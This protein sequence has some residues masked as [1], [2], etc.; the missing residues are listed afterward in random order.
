[1]DRSLYIAMSGAKQILQAQTA[2]SNN[3]ANVNTTGFRA[4][5]EQFR[6]M[7]VFGSGYPSR[8][9]AMSERPNVD[10][11]PG[12][13]QT[14]GRELDVA[15]Q[16]DGWISVQAKDGSEAYTRAGDL[17]VSSIGLLQ[18]SAGLPVIGNSGPIAIPPAQ[19][20][21]IGVDGTISVVPPG[22]NSPA[23]AV[24]DQIKLVKP[25]I[26]QL[27]KSNDGLLRL[28]ERGSFPP[29]AE[30]KLVAGA[31]EASNV[32]AVDAMVNMI[33]LARQFELNMKMM[34]AVD[35][36]EAASARLMQSA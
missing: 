14:T 15:I 11:T 18:T 35:D 27:E 16:G 29:S 3:L 10:F 34:K 17:R 30:V 13:I 7:P 32:N 33:E 5:F 20:I 36:N 22:S 4:D 2:N 6:S 26:D 31:L 8:V 12:T 25:P 19:K 9:Y 21:E 24:I 28:K 1:V 23:L